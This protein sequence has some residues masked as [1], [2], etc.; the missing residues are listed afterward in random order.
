MV[1][2]PFIK[3]HQGHTWWLGDD[4]HVAGQPDVTGSPALE[5]DGRALEV[6]EHVHDRGEVEVLH[7]ALAP[8]SQRQAQVLQER[9]KGRLR[10]WPL[11]AFNLARVQPQP[12][13]PVPWRCPGS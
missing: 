5:G 4:D 11:G 2:T 9:K 7:S 13:C 12:P 8:L 6:V 1:P 10:P 3:G